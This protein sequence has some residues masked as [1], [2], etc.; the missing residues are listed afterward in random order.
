MNKKAVVI[1]FGRLKGYRKFC[2]KIWNAAR[3][4]DGYPNERDSFESLNDDDKW[5]YEEFQKMK[6]Q[7]FLV[8]C[9]YFF[10]VDIAR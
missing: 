4:I 6:E 3:F 10:Y 7:I 9:P 2:T 1:E 8:N 5:I